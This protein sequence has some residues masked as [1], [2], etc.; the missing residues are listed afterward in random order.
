[1]QIKAL[2]MHK[3]TVRLELYI[4]TLFFWHF[5][6]G[7]L[8]NLGVKHLTGQIITWKIQPLPSKF[9]CFPVV[10]VFINSNATK[11]L[12]LLLFTHR[13]TYSFAE[14]SCGD[15]SA[16]FVLRV[17]ASST[18][19]D[20]HTWWF[21]E[22]VGG[23]PKLPAHVDTHFPG[24]ALCLPPFW[25]YA[26][27]KQVGSQTSQPF[28]TAAV[29]T[30]EDAEAQDTCIIIFSIFDTYWAT[31]HNWSI[32]FSNWRHIFL[33][34]YSISG[35][36]ILLRSSLYLDR[37]PASPPPPHTPYQISF[38]SFCRATKG[39]KKQEHTPVD[40]KAQTRHAH[41]H[42]WRQIRNFSQPHIHFSG[43]RRRITEE[44]GP[45][46]TKTP[47]LDWTILARSGQRPLTEWVTGGVGDPLLGMMQTCKTDWL[48]K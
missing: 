47:K 20:G 15:I 14:V 16:L 10:S 23:S 48:F 28:N 29:H 32:K 33:N 8:E 18:S 36:G 46:F 41:T 42:T 22:Y 19:V 45:V 6:R 3:V 30:H 35:I 37:L 25:L 11:I 21:I 7:E 39:D 1:M 44:P 40:C 43:L 5:F 12:N 38:K 26:C 4:S 9:L 2:N 27:I 17:A 34:N 31:R 24:N 13:R